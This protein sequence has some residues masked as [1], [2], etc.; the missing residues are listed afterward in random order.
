MSKHQTNC[1][2]TPPTLFYCTKLFKRNVVVSLRVVI[3]K[4]CRNLFENLDT[5]KALL[6]KSFR[7]LYTSARP[8][9]SEKAL[10]NSPQSIQKLFCDVVNNIFHHTPFNWWLVGCVD[11]ILSWFFQWQLLFLKWKK[12]VCSARLIAFSLLIFYT[13]AM[14][15]AF[16][17]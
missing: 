10:V 17:I 16:S 4:Y 3:K 7:S 13:F 9:N 2:C 14:S 1:Y 11:L 12:S 15:L 8:S 6:E 5:I